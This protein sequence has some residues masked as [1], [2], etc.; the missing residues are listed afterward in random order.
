MDDSIVGVL[1]IQIRVAEA[2][3]Y[4][5]DRRFHLT[6]LQRQRKRYMY[7]SLPRPKALD[8]H[9]YS[10]LSRI[11][12]PFLCIP[13]IPISILLRFIFSCAGTDRDTHNDTDTDHS[14][15]FMMCS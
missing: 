6:P 9:L 2:D 7:L 5:P 3:T 11:P 1:P 10:Y 12:Y 13:S 4:N 8:S 15:S 14:S